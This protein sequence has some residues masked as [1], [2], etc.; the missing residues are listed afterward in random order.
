[1][2]AGFSQFVREIVVP[3]IG[4]KRNNKKRKTKERE[5]SAIFPFSIIFP[6]YFKVS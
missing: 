4:H 5:T 3:C 1:M 2:H 6:I